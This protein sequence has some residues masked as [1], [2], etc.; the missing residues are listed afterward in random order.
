M[1]EFSLG[2]VLLCSAAI[3]MLLGGLAGAEG[4]KNDLVARW[5]EQVHEG[6]MQGDFCITP[7]NVAVPRPEWSK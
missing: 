6:Q 4:A 7:E 5:C 3:A 2:V 1:T